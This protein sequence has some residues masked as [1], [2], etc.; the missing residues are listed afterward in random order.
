MMDLMQLQAKDMMDLVDS[1]EEV[2]L[3]ST[4]PNR[5]KRAV[6]VDHH[7]SAAATKLES[8][9]E[10]VYELTIEPTDP[11]DEVS[12]VET[13]APKRNRK[14]K[15]IDYMEVDTEDFI[16]I[17][18]VSDTKAVV[19]AA[20]AAP[21]LINGCNPAEQRMILRHLHEYTESFESVVGPWVNQLPENH[22]WLP[23]P[24]SPD[25]VQ[26]WINTAQAAPLPRGH[27]WEQIAGMLKAG[28][29]AAEVLEI[30]AVINHSQWLRYR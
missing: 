5:K 15:K 1:D 17:Q 3:V 19:P 8:A 10:V 16:Y 22:A 27:L 20:A 12:I 26:D 2:T 21:K 30:T 7:D 4:T 6:H 18:D 13:A 9:E 25:D 23:P 29:P 14:R 11:T 28:V 24:S